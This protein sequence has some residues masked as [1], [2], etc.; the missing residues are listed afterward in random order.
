MSGNGGSNRES[1]P[2]LY[3]NISKDGFLFKKKSYPTNINGLQE[4]DYLYDF[5]ASVNN[6]DY[7]FRISIVHTFRRGSH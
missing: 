6:E 3:N 5:N 4:N 7:V 1:Y 2:I